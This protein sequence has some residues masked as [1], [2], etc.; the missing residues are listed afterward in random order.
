MKA[1]STFL[2]RVFAMHPLAMIVGLCLIA[3]T[4]PAVR[5]EWKRGSEPSVQQV[6]EEVVKEDVMP[7]VSSA[8][9]TING[10]PKMVVDLF[11][12]K[13]TELKTEF[14]GQLN[15]LREETVGPKGQAA[16]LRTDLL[17]PDR[18]VVPGL[19][20]AVIAALI[21]PKSGALKDVAPA[22]AELKSAAANVND[23]TKHAKAALPDFT[24]CAYEDPMTGEPLG[25][26]PDCFFNRFQGTSKAIETAARNVGVMSDDLKE[27]LPA[28]TD[29]SKKIGKN[30][31][32]ATAEAIN[33]AKQS[34]RFLKN[35]AD[36]TTPLPKIIRYPAQAIGL[37]GSA[38]LPVIGIEKLVTAGNIPSTVVQ[39]VKSGA[40]ARQSA[41]QSAFTQRV[42][43]S[44]FCQ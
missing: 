26:N 44:M 16:A 43:I 7:P 8:V 33:T 17:D 12:R 42:C 5:W 21:D 29:L 24:D 18:G 30:S 10:V 25:G 4:I 34:T 2:A 22:L 32:D 6:V 36:N 37:I 20:K 28:I 40:P 9:S 41:A 35:L 19:Q 14:S 23:I 1:D 11:D 39:A 3:L 38:V 15:K 13:T 27:K 31:D